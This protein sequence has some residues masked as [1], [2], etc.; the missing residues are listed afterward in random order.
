MTTRLKNGVRVGVAACA[1]GLSLA[2]P[3]AVGVASADR[4]D[5]TFGVTSSSPEEGVDSSV[6]PSRPAPTGR[7]AAVLPPK[8]RS[9]TDGAPS[10]SRAV[11]DPVAAARVERSRASQVAAP[12]DPAS[13]SAEPEVKKPTIARTAATSWVVT[14]G[15]SQ[16]TDNPVIAPVDAASAVVAAR[17]SR[18]TRFTVL[19]ADRASLAA[20]IMRRMAVEVVRFAQFLD[21]ATARLVGLPGNPINELVAGT[22][23]LV[24]R[25]L[26]PLVPTI[27]QVTVSSTTASE[28]WPGDSQSAVFTVTLKEAYARTVT[29]QYETTDVTATS[30]EDYVAASGDLV[31]A[32]GEV[33]KT[34][35]V[36]VL[37]DSTEEADEAFRLV[38][39]AAEGLPDAADARFPKI[40]ALGMRFA[41]FLPV[42]E[43]TLATGTGTIIDQGSALGQFLIKNWGS[44]PTYYSLA[45]PVPIGVCFG[46]GSNTGANTAAGCNPPS[47][48]PAGQGGALY[49]AT[50][51]QTDPT[52]TVYYDFGGGDP[53]E[54]QWWNVASLSAL[55]DYMSKLQGYYQGIFYD[56]EVFDPTNFDV[57][58]MYSAFDQSFQQAKSLGLTVMVSTSYTAPYN[59]NG[60]PG[61]SLT[62][63]LWQKI[64]ADSNVDFFAPQFYG[65]GTTASIANTYGSTVTFSTWTSTIV[66][67]G[68]GKIVPI[69]K[70]WSADALDNQ[71]GQVSSACSTI[72]Q[73][74]CS[75][76]YLLWGST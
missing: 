15:P 40:L 35:S 53:Q 49:Q 23:L 8:K 63:Q 17:I 26:L 10:A 48:D 58:A 44:N 20:P 62:D 75:G 41:S 54:S 76:G 22:L 12:T 52:G 18:E 33:S 55:N 56:I 1:L 19:Q 2:G 59:A 36:T 65:D 46:G 68:D 25:A 73:S 29:V 37:S 3:Y 9:G 64:L 47:D 14:R 6:A 45:A 27:P 28:G 34:V 11:G 74:F 38:I 13:S 5:G 32:P 66:G 42:T 43:V 50:K 70:A 57:D 39:S 7:R 51:L 61:L 67:G 72:G 60:G 21:A 30:G 31:F 69:L 16:L 4:R 24:R 71:I